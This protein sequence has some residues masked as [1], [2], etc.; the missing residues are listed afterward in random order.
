MSDAAKKQHMKKVFSHKPSR[1]LT[2]PDSASGASSLQGTY[3][4]FLASQ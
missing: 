2:N 4:L 3:H 1:V